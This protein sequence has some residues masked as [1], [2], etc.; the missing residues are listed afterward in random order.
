LLSALVA[1]GSQ[2]EPFLI[3]DAG[4]TAHGAPTLADAI[5]YWRSLQPKGEAYI[6]LTQIPA[7]RLSSLGIH[8]ETALETCANLEIGYHLLSTAYEKASKVEKSPWKTIS[9]TYAIF[10]ANQVAIDLPYA[11]KAT[12]HLM[13]RPAVAPAPLGSPL[14]HAITAEWSAGLASRLAARHLSPTPT[15]LAEASR[16]AAWARSQY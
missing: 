4:G 16:I 1:A 10:R 5:T 6:G 15:P 2:G 9:I 8:P 12:D 3:S 7:S 13:G 14:R 11:R